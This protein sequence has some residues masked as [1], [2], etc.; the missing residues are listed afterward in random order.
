MLKEL[1]MKV[2][3]CE[4]GCQYEVICIFRFKEKAKNLKLLKNILVT[5][6]CPSIRQARQ[7][8]ATVN[9]KKITSKRKSIDNTYENFLSNNNEMILFLA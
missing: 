8:E 9:L 1:R 3:I 2:I 5:G 6:R 7:T 4:W